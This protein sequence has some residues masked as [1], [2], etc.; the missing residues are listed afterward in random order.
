[1]IELCS[2]EKC[3][4][5]GACYNACPKHCIIM[6]PE[7]VEGFLYPVINTEHCV[8]CGLCRKSCPILTPLSPKCEPVVYAAWNLDD[9]IRQ[10]SSSGGMFYSFAE[11]VIR[12]GGVVYGVVMS[13]DGTVQHQ[14][15]ESV[16]ELT[17]MKGSK[18]VQ[19]DTRKSYSEALDDLR[20]GRKVMFTGTPC[21]VAAFRSFLNKRSYDN[22]LLVDIVCHGVPSNKLFKVYLKKL[23]KEKGW[24]VCK[25]SFTFRE[26]KAW[27]YA[28]SVKLADGTC[29]QI[30]PQD[31]VY[32]RHFLSSYTCRESCYN[33][34]FS[35]TPR[36]S[37]ITIADFWGIGSES[38][39]DGDPKKGC[40][41]VLIN[42]EAGKDAF[43]AIKS[44]LFYE[45]RTLSE[46][47]NVNHQ[48]YRPSERPKH[49]NGAY[50]YF[51]SHSIAGIYSH[52]YNTPYHKL[53]HFVGKILR[54]INVI[55]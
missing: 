49:R 12:T 46:A 16:Q 2:S 55:K 17:P 14:R 9:G 3:T 39:F 27:G 30:S 41:L 28:P 35:M 32:M 24:S 50:G 45:K 51:F 34:I 15:A 48:L 7:G 40:S 44:R 36:Q 20:Q 33:C 10:T 6:V 1:M 52:Y 21:Q 25:S 22:L 11:A 23:E 18:Y 26:F 53:R 43:D 13:G 8:E 5:C 19:S 47:M 37:D 29:Q 38:H 4:G 31:D 42:S 54:A